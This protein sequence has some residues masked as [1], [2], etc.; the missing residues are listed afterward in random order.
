MNYAVSFNVRIPSCILGVIKN[1]YLSPLFVYAHHVSGPSLLLL[2]I[3]PMQNSK[4]V[5]APF[6]RDVR[7]NTVLRVGSHVKYSTWLCLMLYLPLNL[8]PI[9]YFPYI[10]HNGALSY[11]LQL[12]LNITHACQYTHVPAGL[13]HVKLKN[14][15]YTCTVAHNC[16]VRTTVSEHT[17]HTSDA[18]HKLALGLPQYMCGVQV[19]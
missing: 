11:T 4:S 15:A 1:H 3:F 17:Q 12:N 10:T 13:P 5:K 8:T 16:G 18:R 19:Q 2:L 7:K 6:T 9:L 14:L